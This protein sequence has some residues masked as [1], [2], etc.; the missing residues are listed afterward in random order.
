MDER[1]L[2]QEGSGRQV[3]VDEQGNPSPLSVKPDEVLRV[4]DGKAYAVKG[5]S[6]E[7]RS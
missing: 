4:S 5:E 1:W 6:E 3:F 2:E 7:G